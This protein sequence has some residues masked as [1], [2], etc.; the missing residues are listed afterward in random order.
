M[1][2]NNL[3]FMSSSLSTMNSTIIGILGHGEI[4]ASVDNV[5]NLAGYTNIKIKDMRLGFNDS[6]SE[7]KFVNI[8]IPFFGYDSFIST[9]K[10]LHLEKGT[11]L[12]IQSTIGIGTTDKIQNLLPDVVCVHSP[13][14][15]VHPNLTDGL[16]TFEKYL[17]VSDKY[18]SDKD[19]C[20]SIENHVNSLNMTPVVCCAR[21]SELAKMVST[22]LY[23]INIAAIT[24][25]SRM[26]E[27]YKVDFD[28]VF[29]RWQTGYNDGYSK[30][31][32]PNVCR[33]VLTPIPKNEEGERVIGGHCVIPNSVILKNMGEDA[34]SEFVLRYSDE[35]SIKHV[36]NAKH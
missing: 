9:I 30:L 24:D 35:K 1:S 6:L 36:T 16:L 27:K 31:G 21:E 15:G 13:V 7:C 32:K 25:V 26:C 29:T 5:Y 3:S 22:T 10:D 19:I 12:L 28:T 11:V 33:P 23:G 14:R 17:G 2:L 4:G 8:C 18:F 34:V 20:S